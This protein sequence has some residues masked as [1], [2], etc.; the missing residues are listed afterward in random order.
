MTE[1]LP[2]ADELSAVFARTAGLLL[3][4]ETATA[5]VRLVTALAADVIPDATGCGVTL[6]DGS[7][8]ATTTA[9]TNPLVEHA[10]RLQYELAGGPCLTAFEQRVVV[11]MDDLDV[12]PRW[13]GWVAAVLQLGVRSVLSAPLVAGDRCV[14]ALKVYSEQPRAFDEVTERRLTL[15]AAQA[16][17]VLANVQSAETARRLSDDLKNALRTRDAV[18]AAKGVL[19]ARNAVDE[20]AGLALLLGQAQREGRPL[21]DVARAVARSTVRRRR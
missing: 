4:Q 3:S 10:D 15:F 1:T 13:P 14:G 18:S 9:A 19:M 5:A 2:L 12:D 21:R 11:R 6:V 16:A 8:A 20:D 7:G 17:I